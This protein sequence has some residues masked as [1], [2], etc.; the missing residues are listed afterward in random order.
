[1]NDL[2]R[3]ILWLST[4]GVL[5]VGVWGFQWDEQ[6]A[7]RPFAP[8]NRAFRLAHQVSIFG[9]DFHIPFRGM[10]Y[11]WGAILCAAAALWPLATP[12]RSARW[13]GSWDRRAPSP[14]PRRPS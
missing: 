13:L 7:A 1:M 12:P 3:L 5:A 8:E 14:T 6:S 2:R 10:L 11:D 9:H 4:L